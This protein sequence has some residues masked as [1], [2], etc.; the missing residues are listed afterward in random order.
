MISQAKTVANYI[1]GLPED[2]KANFQEL[3][4]VITANIPDGFE[5]VMQYG[6]PGFVVPHSRYPAGYHCQP[7]DPLPFVSLA[8]QKQGIHFY[9]MGLYARPDLLDWFRDEFPKH[10]KRKLDMGK[11]CVR[12][13]GG[14]DIPY[15]LIGEL[16]QKLTVEDY[17]KLYEAGRG[18]KK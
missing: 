17:I 16:M 2:R 11:S 12:F 15:A 5:L 3:L 1:S 10:S 8:N 13:R 9:H 18:T 6:M 14:K 4:D 7:S